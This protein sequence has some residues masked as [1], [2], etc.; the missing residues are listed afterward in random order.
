MEVVTG[1]AIFLLFFFCILKRGMARH[2]DF[3]NVMY[4][5]EKSFRRKYMC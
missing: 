5:Y 2:D 3:Q 4:I 1:M